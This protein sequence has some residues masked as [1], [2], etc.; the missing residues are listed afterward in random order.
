[1]KSLQELV[2]QVGPLD[3]KRAASYVEEVAQQLTERH[4][5]GQLHRDIRP[6]HV[7]LDET[8]SAR[9]AESVEIS[10]A[11]YR[12]TADVAD[13][14]APEQ[15]LSV[16]KSDGRADNYSLGCVL[17]FLLVGR[18]PFA[19]DS[20]SE[21]LLMHQSRKPEAISN[22]R[23]DVPHTLAHICETMMAKKPGGRYQSVDA[24]IQAIATWRRSVG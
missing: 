23:P 10:N 19:S 18:A 4:R 13:Y 24:V 12:D 8:G 16:T 1:M 17:Y 9:L 6:R 5:A 3:Y 21:R 22:L 20:I 2:Q 14:L 15:A 7:L 11:D